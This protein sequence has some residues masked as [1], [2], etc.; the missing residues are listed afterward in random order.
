MSHPDSS[1]APPSTAQPATQIA[2]EMTDV[3]VGSLSDPNAVVL[4]E[5]NWKVAL[6]DYWVVGGLQGS[7]K[8]DFM[9]TAAGI[10]APLRGHLRIFGKELGAGFEHELMPTRL[11]LGLVFDGGRLLNHLTIAENVALPIGYHQNLSLAEAEARTR[12]LLEITELLEW[13][14]RTPG[15]MHPNLRQRVGLARA[16]ALKPEVLLLDNPLRGLDPR[17]S[18]WWLE[19]ID[20]L[21]AGHPFLN[22]RPMTL[23]V[24]EDNL[25]WWRN[26]ARQFAVLT[27]RTLLII[28]DR[29]ELT[30]SKELLVQ[31]LLRSDLVTT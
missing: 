6:G 21:C 24:T 22:G 30:E 7:G 13:A 10:M 8:S 5:V 18:L 4:E 23:V 2:L 1:T 3:S 31:E 11:R 19:L 14:H 28:G 20:Q 26:R 12:S 27:N 9:A 16:L 29:S 25:R 15:A 17:D